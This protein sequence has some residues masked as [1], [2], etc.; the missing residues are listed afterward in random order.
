MMS[1]SVSDLLIRADRRESKRRNAM[2]V[3][4]IDLKNAHNRVIGKLYGKC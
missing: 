2:H 3:G 4:F 1:K